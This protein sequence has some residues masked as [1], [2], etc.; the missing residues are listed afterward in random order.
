MQDTI[1]LSEYYGTLH[2][3]EKDLDDLWDFIRSRKEIRVC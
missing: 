3:M 1:V 2:E